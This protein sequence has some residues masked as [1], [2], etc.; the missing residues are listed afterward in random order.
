MCICFDIVTIFPSIIRAYLGES[1]L[2]RAVQNG[3]LDVKVYDLR[4]YTAD[5]HRT[6][7][8]TPYGGGS[9]MV[10]KVEPMFTA[11]K[12]I[13]SDGQQRRK[14]L[15]SPQGRTYDQSVAEELSGDKRRLLMICGRYEGIDERVRETLIDEEISIGDYVMTG[16]ELASLVIIDSVA[17]L[18]PGVLGDDESAKEESFSWGIL[19]Y[20][21]YTRPPEFM[22]HRVP[23]MLLSGNHAKI[24]EWRRKE[25]LRRTLEKRPDLL[26]TAALS[27]TDRKM[28]QELCSQKEIILSEEN[29]ELDKGSRREI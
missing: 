29:D 10:M 11:L 18:C 4:D 27:A 7:D 26:K 3:L 12:A 21:H 1:I 23:D 17:R 14:I 19:D 15:L 28:L 13:S 6:V 2:K 16:G 25:A 9:G 8:D 22:G 24:A 20:P 5:R